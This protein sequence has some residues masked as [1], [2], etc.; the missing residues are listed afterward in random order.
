MTLNFF[1]VK[2]ISGCCYTACSFDKKKRVVVL[3]LHTGV[4]LI[5]DEKKKKILDLIDETK[6]NAIK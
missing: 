4:E 2:L 6:I 3:Q 5:T 1:H